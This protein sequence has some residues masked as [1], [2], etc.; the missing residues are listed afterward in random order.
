MSRSLE[1]EYRPYTSLANA[2]IENAAS[3][4]KRANQYLLKHSDKSDNALYSDA[5]RKY[6]SQMIDCERFFLSEW[7][8]VLTNLDG[9]VLLEMLQDTYG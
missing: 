3:E 2:I 6:K 5:M 7:F 8:D 4:W 9:E 1:K